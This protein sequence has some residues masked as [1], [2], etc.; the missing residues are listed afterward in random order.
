MTGIRRRSFLASSLGILAGCTAPPPR[1]PSPGARI[2]VV[3]GGFGGAT[4][5]R[6]LRLLDPSLDVTLIEP[7]RHFITCPFS[8]L[9]LAGLGTLE[10]ITHGYEALR[11]RHGVRVIHDR[12]A[13]LDPVGRRLVTAKGERIAF[14]RAVVSPGISIR[15]NAV[16]GYDEAAA[17]RMPHAWKAGAQTRLLRRQ[18]EAMPDGGT[19]IIAV[20]GEPF[21]CPPGPYERASLVAHYFRTTKPKSKILVLDTKDSFSKQSLFLEGWKALYPGIIEWVAG[22]DGGRVEEVDAKA[23]TVTADSGFATHKADVVNFIPPQQAGEIALRADLADRTGWCP[24][25]QRTFESVRH[26]YIHV[27]G[28]ACIAGKMPKSGFS[29]NSQAKVCA[30]AIVASLSGATLPSPSYANTCYSLVGPEY[31]IS[32]ADVYRLADGQILPVEG[33]GGI[34]PLGADAAFRR[35][36]AKYARGWYESIIA[37]TFS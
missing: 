8:N 22:T 16:P 19:F 32:V 36:E 7:E 1:S 21:R 5:A 30:A 28:D 17:E 23:M 27:I 15:W 10:S 4:C 14:D 25:D 31:G 3:G 26:P 33:A 9:Y 35:D 29:A 18:L 13:D 6:Y 12:V 20:P 24:V 2:V 37:D 11:D 34:S